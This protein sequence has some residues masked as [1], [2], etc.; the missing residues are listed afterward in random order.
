MVE[1][2]RK[3]RASDLYPYPPEVMAIGTA[4]IDPDPIEEYAGI[5]AAG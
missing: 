2:G 5:D 1:A 4:A 3:M